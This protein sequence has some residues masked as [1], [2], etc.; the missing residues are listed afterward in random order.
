MLADLDVAVERAGD[1]ANALTALGVVDPE[2]L[3][4]KVLAEAAVGQSTPSRIPGADGSIIN[5]GYRACFSVQVE[6]PA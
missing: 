3:V 2:Q 6:R 4:G 5:S 1:D